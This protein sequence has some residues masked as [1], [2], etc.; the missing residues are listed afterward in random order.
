MCECGE[1]R[2]P[3]RGA[4]S[5]LVT[6]AAREW[7]ITRKF[8]RRGQYGGVVCVICHKPMEISTR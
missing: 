5:M 3:G 4:R 1:T 8:A 2:C 7:L 6:E